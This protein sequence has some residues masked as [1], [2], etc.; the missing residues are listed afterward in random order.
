MSEVNTKNVQIEKFKLELMDRY[1]ILMLL[2]LGVYAVIF[3]FFIHDKM[4]SWYL[5]IGLFFS[6]YTYSIVRK[7][8]PISLIVHLYLLFAPIY[9][10]YIMLAFWNNSVA[11]FCWLLPIPLGAYIFF[12]KK[13]VLLYVAYILLLIITGYIAANNFNFTFPE[14]TQKEVIF[15]DTIL[16]ISNILVVSLLI[17]YKDKIRKLEILS[18]IE[19]TVIRKDEIQTPTENSWDDIDVESMKKLFE[20]IETAM[21][22]NKLFKDDKFN[23]SKLSVALDVNSTYISK[24]IRY[25]GYSNFNTYLNIYRINYV[26]KLFTE[27]DFQKTTLMYIYTEAGFSNQSTFNRV[28][29]QIVGITPSEYAQQNPQTNIDL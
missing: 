6:G 2:V 18:Q 23:L 7:K 22:E 3:T 8:Y 25:K 14:H 5:M 15:T 10:F 16:F 4:M 1:T 27:I 11:S 13:E 20:K 9:N 19:S 17:Y 26:K 21:T 28:F 12:S 29:K 24:A